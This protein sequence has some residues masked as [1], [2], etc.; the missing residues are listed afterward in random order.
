[1]NNAEHIYGGIHY[2]F[3]I[4]KP[5][6]HGAKFDYIRDIIRTGAPV[7]RAGGEGRFHPEAFDSTRYRFSSGNLV[8]NLFDIDNYSIVILSHIPYKASLL[9]AGLKIRCGSWRTPGPHTVTVSA[10]LGPSLP[11]GTLHIRYNLT[12]SAYIT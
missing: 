4:D 3:P 7:G 9:I 2:L 5:I 8:R 6:T 12:I 1:M 11:I 10:T